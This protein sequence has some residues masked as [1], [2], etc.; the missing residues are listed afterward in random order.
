MATISV[1]TDFDV[2]SKYES[3]VKE[4]LDG[5]SAYI[6][7][8]E[9]L[10]EL[11]DDNSISESD[12]ST[13]LTG[14]IGAA[15][16]TI[17]TSSMSAAVQWAQAEKEFALRKLEAELQL[18]ILAEEKALKKAQAEQIASNSRLAMIESRRM[19]GIA[20]FDAND[21]I[22]SL[23]ESGKVWS[24]MQLTETQKDKILA[25]KGLVEQKV[26]ES[27][28]AV[29]KIV[30]DT[31]VNYG[32][33]TYSVPAV[34]GIGTVT[35]QHGAYKT[36]S[37][38]QREIAVEQAKG[39]TYNAWANALTG[40]AS[41]LGTAIAAEYAEFGAGQPGGIL[42]DTVL[43]AANNLKNASTTVDE[44]IPTN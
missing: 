25:D 11:F 14:I 28:A 22:T 6:R 9:T 20:T 38:T 24:D 29:H 32:N 18:D 34:S 35:T 4:S 12:R 36:L 19:Y 37:D 33:Y 2:L 44:A 43:D 30:A 21:N 27:Y 17:T 5:E 10:Q 26:V 16:N 1:T 3:L 13:I 15:V 41:M 31:Y 42:L 23:D 39:Y 40:S 8:K 7:A